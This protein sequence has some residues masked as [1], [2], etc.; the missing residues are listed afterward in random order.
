MRSKIN[1]SVA[2]AAP[3]EFQPLQL[4]SRSIDPPVV[5]APMSGVTNAPFRS[6]CRRFS[7][8]RCLYISEMITARSFVVGHAKTRRL[9]SFGEDEEFKSIQLYGTQPD[10]LGA[11]AEILVSE[12]GVDHIDINFGCPVRK[13]TAVGGGSA[14]PLRPRLM[15]RLLAAVVKNAGKVPV[16][17]KF[18]TGIDA[19]LITYRD[20]GRVAQE[21]GCAAVALH[22]RSAAQLYHGAADWQPIA[23]LKS[24]LTIPVLGNGDI[25]EGFDALRM[26]RE[27]GADGVVVGR[28]CLGRPWIFRDLVDVFDGREPQTPP[29]LGRVIEIAL[30]H[31]RLLCDF[32]GEQVAMLHMRKF[33][34]W[35][36]KSFA[37][38]KSL[39]PK[40]HLVR[41][42]AEL[43]CLL[44][45]LD[46]EAPY[47][48]AAL[49]VRRGKSGRTQTVAL[50]AGILEDRESAEPLWSAEGADGEGG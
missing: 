13:V 11:A 1:Q 8:Q 34:G 30:E 23:D 50:P 4:G 2:L 24:R 18:R 40:L 45:T 28:A 9:A 29:N 19:Q 48:E 27:T 16:T 36:L 31:A 26:M 3:G 38:A 49:R 46:Q 47:P 20:A 10:S 32:F 42:L 25:F 6:L 17:V 39:L 33:S 12:W 37:H 5:L 22:G 41:S 21:Q 43:E 7:D 35:Y 14:I 15:A 44:A